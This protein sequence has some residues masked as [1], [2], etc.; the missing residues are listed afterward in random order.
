LIP[1]TFP[2]LIDDCSRVVVRGSSNRYWDQPELTEPIFHLFL[3]Q[4]DH[5]YRM[6]S[7][8]ENTGVPLTTLYSWRE[9]GRAH[10][11][12]R[13]SHERFE[14]TNRA[15]PGDAEAIIARF[16][17]SNFVAL[18]RGLERPTLTSIVLMLI[19]SMAAEQF[20][21]PTILNMND[22]TI[23]WAAFC[24]DITLAS[25]ALGRPEEDL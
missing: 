18:G 23:S 16:I 6:Q 13:T 19:H 24:G 9:R 17:R 4:P 22:R 14:M 11:E 12:W 2:I 25:G 21:E 1:F 10:A 5:L 15:L 3:T 20:L 7:V 8:H